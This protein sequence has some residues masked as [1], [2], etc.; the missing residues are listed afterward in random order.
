VATVKCRF[1]PVP[2]GP[3]KRTLLTACW[4]DP[5]A[6][7]ASAPFFHALSRSYPRYGYR[8]IWAMLRREGWRVSRKRVQRL[9]KGGNRRM[10][11]SFAAPDCK[12]RPR[13]Q[14]RCLSPNGV[15]GLAAFRAM[16]AIRITARRDIACVTF[17][18]LTT[19]DCCRPA[20]TCVV[21]PVYEIGHRVVELLLPRI[22][23]GGAKGP[24]EKVK[25]SAKLVIRESSESVMALA[26]GNHGATTHVTR[27]KR[28]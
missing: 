3:K 8:R 18:G 4:R 20:I 1:P 12:T 19:E 5:V 24:V 26:N 10:L 13:A 21:R 7:P 6:S 23:D 16:Y 28:T 2:L 11:Q 9:W 15:T 25:L 27:E 22:A 14:P 17:D